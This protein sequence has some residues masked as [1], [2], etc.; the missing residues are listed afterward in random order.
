M[1]AYSAATSAAWT[2]SGG[3]AGDHADHAGR[4]AHALGQLRNGETLLAIDSLI[5]QRLQLVE[6][7]SI[8][9]AHAA[10]RFSLGKHSAWCQ[11]VSPQAEKG[12]AE[13]KRGSGQG[14]AIVANKVKGI[15]AAVVYDE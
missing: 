12:R 9:G 2:A 6:K 5:H 3:G 8:F 11:E 4:D 15:R 14:E 13:Q 10:A 1:T 7:M